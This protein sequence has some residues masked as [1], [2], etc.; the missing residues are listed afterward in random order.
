[1][2]A[3]EYLFN[4]FW[5]LTSIATITLGIYGATHDGGYLDLMA[6]LIGGFSAG[7]QASELWHRFEALVM[8]VDQ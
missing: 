4:L 8:G 7:V 1:M 2:K 5:T 3:Q 6:I